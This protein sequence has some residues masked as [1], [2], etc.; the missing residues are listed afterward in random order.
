MKK[1]EIIKKVISQEYMYICTNDV[2]FLDVYNA[3]INK[4]NCCG[5]IK[6]TINSSNNYYIIEVNKNDN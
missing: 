3:A 4:D 1:L 2:I 6:T 5:T